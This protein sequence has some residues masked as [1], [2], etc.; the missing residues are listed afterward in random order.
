[1][2]FVPDIEPATLQLVQAVADALSGKTTPLLLKLE[3]EE[4][5]RSLLPSFALGL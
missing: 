2:A 5:R 4:R 1:M 3:G